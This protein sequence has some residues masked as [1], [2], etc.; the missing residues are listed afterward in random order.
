MAISVNGNPLLTDYSVQENATSLDPN[1]INSGFG[2]LTYTTNQDHPKLETDVQLNDNLR[3]RF[4]GTV[5]ALS[6]VDGLTSVTADSALSKLN[7]WYTVLPFS[8]TLAN[9]LRFI[10]NLVGS[11]IPFE[12]GISRNIVAPGYVGNVWEGFKKFL[13][14]NQLEAAQV[15]G[16][17]VVRVPRTMTTYDRERTTESWNLSSQGTA[18]WV[19]V[20]WYDCSPIAPNLEMFPPLEQEDEFSPFTV[21]AGQT[22]TQD[23]TIQG[24]VISVNQPMCLD[25]VPANTDYTG[26]EGV[27]CVAGNDGKPILADR[28]KAGGGNLQV[29]TTDDPSVIRVTITGSRIEE[30][31]PYRI[32]TTA[33]TSSYYN[34][35]HITGEGMRWRKNDIEMHTGAT[36][37]TN[38]AETSVEID[39]VNI[40]SLA[41]AYTAAINAGK[42]LS[43][44]I[45]GM[46]GTA[47]SLNRPDNRAGGT[48]PLISAFNTKHPG[49]LVSGFN[50]TYAGM[51]FKQFNDLWLSFVEDELI[52]Q[53]FGN[54]IGARAKRGDAWYRVGSTTTN[55]SNVAYTLDMDTLLNDFNLVHPGM[56]ISEFNT[57]FTGYR[58]LDFNER[59]LQ[60]G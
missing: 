39:N 8:G 24:S 35:L 10:E 6:G 32:A 11:D 13:A 14:A 26:T 4:I 43:G 27:Y 22:V 7:R 50:T 29:S 51:T 54:V 45:M 12:T 30:Y 23:I 34:S 49:M 15:A 1:N 40:T 18:E 44:G 2:Q 53:A 38:A 5:N 33:G 9:Y 55:A 42:N 20:N 52:A 37:G 58:F 59:P 41:M 60:N 21:D 36:R 57:L 25:Y 19:K 48:F 16:R 56:K 28:W 31:G 47:V 17:I 46:S 3:G